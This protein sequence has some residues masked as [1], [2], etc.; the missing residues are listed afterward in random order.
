MIRQSV[1]MTC[2][3]LALGACVDQSVTNRNAASSLADERAITNRN[4]SFNL[5]DERAITNRNAQGSWDD[6]P[7]TNRNAAGP[8]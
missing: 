4:A 7:V 5:L 6:E 2:L 1:L 8:F 3:A